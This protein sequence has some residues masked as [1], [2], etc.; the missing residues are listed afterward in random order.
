MAEEI[1][2]AT[3]V[4]PQALLLSVGINGCL[5]FGMLIARPVLRARVTHGIPVHGDLLPSN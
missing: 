4:V 1:V 3:R 2:N 5:G